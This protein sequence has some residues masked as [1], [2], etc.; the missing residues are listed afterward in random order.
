MF[1]ISGGPGAGKTTLLA[2]LH[3]LG[4]STAPEVARQIIQTQVKSGGDALP[5]ADKEAYIRL[6]LQRSIESYLEHATLPGPIFFDRGILDTLC[7][8]RL[9]GLPDASEIEDA[10]RTYRYA[11]QALLAPPWQE[12]YATDEE[13]KQDFA[14]AVRTYENIAEV[15]AEYGYETVILPTTDPA[16]RAEFVLQTINHAGRNL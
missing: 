10:C 16:A 6:M 7:Y 11:S 3:K 13:R 8:A 4:Y 14:E 1:M 2:E 15:Y 9:I 12:I 5:W